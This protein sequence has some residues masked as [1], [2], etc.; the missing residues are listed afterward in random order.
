MDP[1]SSG[2]QSMNWLFEDGIM[3][4]PGKLFG[5]VGRG[6]H[7]AWQG[8]K[9]AGRKA[10]NAAGEVG[11]IVGT[12]LA[13]VLDPI[14]DAGRAVA[15]A[16]GEA[17]R[18]A[19]RAVVDAGRNVAGR[20][21]NGIRRFFGAEAVEDKPVDPPSSEPMEPEKKGWFQKFNPLR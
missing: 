4:V 20:V 15:D 5:A 3:G 13:P 10:R 19:G 6:I 16:V 17:G 21:S 8:A 12:V 1:N 18:K 9:W 7:D 11:R 2:K 14:I